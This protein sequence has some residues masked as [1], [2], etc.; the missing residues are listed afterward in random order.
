M[1]ALISMHSFT[2]LHCAESDGGEEIQSNTNSDCV[3]IVPLY[4]YLDARLRKKKKKSNNNNNKKT[5]IDI[6]KLYCDKFLI[7]GSESHNLEN[8]YDRCNNRGIFQIYYR[9]RIEGIN[10][11]NGVNLFGRAKLQ[12]KKM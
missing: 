2:M 10:V 11:L 7:H 6:F 8:G 3:S 4:L 5:T 9:D 12:W 1:Q